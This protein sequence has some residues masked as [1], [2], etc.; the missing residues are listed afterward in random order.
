MAL[1]KAASVEITHMVPGPGGGK[2]GR[3]HLVVS[4]LGPEQQ[5]VN[6]KNFGEINVYH[7]LNMKYE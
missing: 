3:G 2:E 5:F 1:V 6:S 4:F 7:G